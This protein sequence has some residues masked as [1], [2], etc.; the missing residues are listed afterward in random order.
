M[1]SHCRCREHSYAQKVEEWEAEG[2]KMYDSFVKCYA[3]KWGM[4]SANFWSGSVPVY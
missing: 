1:R 4:L 2:K 3:M